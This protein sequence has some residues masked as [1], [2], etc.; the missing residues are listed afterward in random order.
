ME[1]G[2]SSE[3][4]IWHRTTRDGYGR[5][6]CLGKTVQAHRLSYEAYVGPI[7]EGLEIDHLCCVTDCVNPEHLEPVTRLENLCRKAI[8]RGHVVGGRPYVRKARRTHCP[9]GHPYPDDGP[10]R[11]PKAARCPICFRARIT[12]DRATQAARRRKERAAAW[13]TKAAGGIRPRGRRPSLVTND[14]AHRGA[15]V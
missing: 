9:N 5:A 3:C 10:A 8:R 15:G 12:R 1:C 14:I 13:L 7:P 4:W 2:H 11:F 6:D